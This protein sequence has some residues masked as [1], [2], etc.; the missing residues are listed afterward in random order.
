MENDLLQLK[1]V[2][3]LDCVLFWFAYAFISHCLFGIVFYMVNCWLSLSLHRSKFPVFPCLATLFSVALIFV[4]VI[5]LLINCNLGI[6]SIP[7]IQMKLLMS[8]PVSW[9]L[10]GG[11]VIIEHQSSGWDNSLKGLQN[12][13][14]DQKVACSKLGSIAVLKP[15]EL[16]CVCIANFPSDT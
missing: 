11:S 1:Q 9:V 13:G 3:Y 15:E 4:P 6:N 5:P 7:H 12:P 2:Y 14:Q 16:F 10:S 8:T